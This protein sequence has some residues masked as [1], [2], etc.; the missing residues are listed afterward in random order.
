MVIILR[1]ETSQFSAKTC[2]SYRQS[3]KTTETMLPSTMH[4]TERM[5][6]LTQTPSARHVP[7]FTCLYKS[8]QAM[9]ISSPASTAVPPGEAVYSASG[10]TGRQASGLQR[11]NTGNTMSDQPLHFTAASKTNVFVPFRGAGWPRREML[12]RP[13]TVPVPDSIVTGDKSCAQSSRLV[14]FHHSSI[15][16]EPLWTVKSREFGL[17]WGTCHSCALNVGNSTVIC[18]FWLRQGGKADRHRQYRRSCT[19]IK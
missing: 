4:H 18:Y 3:I 2:F 12:Q 6:Q 5:Q 15:R 19:L 17:G 14:G 1:K 11:C 10:G 9:W 7:T 16:R 13:T 8:P